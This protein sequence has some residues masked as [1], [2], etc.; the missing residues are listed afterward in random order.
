MGKHFLLKTGKR[1]RLTPFKLFESPKA[2]S[3]LASELGWRVFQELAEPACPM[4]I[5][6]K[7]KVH[8]QKVYYHIRRLKASGLIK[9]VGREPRHG[10]VAKFFQA[11]NHALGIRVGKPSSQ[12]VSITSPEHVKALEPFVVKGKL[13]STIIVGSPDPHGPWKARA[14]DSCCAIDFALFIGSLVTKP[15]PNYKLDVEVRD[16]DLKKNLILIGGPTVNMVTRRVND[17]LPVY[18]K[19]ENGVGIVSRLSG[20]EYPDDECGMICMIENPWNKKSRV[21]VLAGNRFPGTRAAVLAW[22]GKLES[23]LAGNKFDKSVVAKVVKGY[24]MDGDGVID[25]PELLE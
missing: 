22:V 23:V 12:E 9:E 14:S 3:A 2:I 19:L 5:A 10:A 1:N 13:N 24:D 20:K 15:L 11:R 21:L 4:D 8:E 6:K 7:L 18:I 17:K 16:K 25:T